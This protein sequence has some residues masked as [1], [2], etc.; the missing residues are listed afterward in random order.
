MAVIPTVPSFVTGDTSV[1]K[2][3]QLSDAVAFLVDIDIRP[4]FRVYK[5]ASSALTVG[6]W[7]KLPGGTLDI[8]N[9]NF[10]SAG[11]GFNPTIQTA[12]HYAFEACVP[13]LTGTTAIGQRISFL[14]TAGA[15]NPNLGTGLTRR[16]GMRGGNSVST[17]GNDTSTCTADHSPFALYPGDVVELQTYVDTAVSSSFNNNVSYISG[18][19]VPSFTGYWIRQAP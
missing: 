5:T 13:L 2:L 9:D 11:I 7:T 16:F 18:R 14:L 10:F 3:Q 15:N 8:D 4:I 12:G 1:T 17:T 19:F 6:A